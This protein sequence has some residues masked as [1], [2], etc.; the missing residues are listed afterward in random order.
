MAIINNIDLTDQVSTTW[1][2]ELNENFNNLNNDKLEKIQTY[3]ELSSLL[4]TDL[5]LLY[6]PDDWTTYSVTVENLLNHDV[7]PV[8]PVQPTWSITSTEGFISK[9]SPDWLYIY[10]NR[11]N[12]TYNELYKKNSDDTDD[13]TLISWNHHIEEFDINN[14]WTE[15]V[16]RNSEDNFLYKKDTS[17]VWDWTA[18]TSVTSYEPAYTNDWTEIVYRNWSDNSFLYKKSSS[19]TSNWSAITS[20]RA[21][22][23]AF[24]SDWLSIY[25][26]WPNPFYIWKKNSWDT[27]NWN[28]VNTVNSSYPSCSPIQNDRFLYQ[29]S[30]DIYLVDDSTSDN[31]NLI[32]TDWKFPTYSPSWK[33]ITYRDNNDNW[34]LHTIED[35]F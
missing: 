27:S 20:Q 19:D 2:T 6:R 21:T 1:V 5:I 31:W 23:P 35:T 9:Y 18:I 11:P 15:I 4:N 26:R 17:T 28:S 7:W 25:Y 13:W 3:T 30:S 33:Y 24:S 32:I 8:Y 14:D 12:W 10:Y 34:L 22:F 16:Y 29:D